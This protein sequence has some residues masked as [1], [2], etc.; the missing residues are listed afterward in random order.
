M[1]VVSEKPSRAGAALKSPPTKPHPLVSLVLLCRWEAPHIQKVMDS[2]LA[3]EDPEGGFEVIVADGMSDDG[4]REILA[5]V[6]ATDSRVRVIDNPGRIASAGLNAALRVARGQVIIRMD[7]HTHYAPDYVRQCVA[8]LERTGADNVGGPWVAQAKGYLGEAIAAAFQSPFAVGG[9]RGHLP[10][11]EGPVDTVYLGCWKREAFERFGGFDEALVRNQDDEHNLRILRGGGRIW[12]SPKIRSWYHSR[13]SLRGLFNQYLQYGYWKVQVIRKHGQPAS[14]RH[15]VPGACLLGVLLLVLTVLL[16]FSA[17]GLCA[18][19]STGGRLA[20]SLLGAALVALGSVVFSYL[21]AL[22]VAALHSA[23]RTKWKLLP[24]LP[25]VFCC[26]HFGY[27]C[28]FLRGLL[29]FVILHR[30]AAPSLSRL[31]RETGTRGK[32][33]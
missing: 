25:L 30:R 1:P 16:S 23:R 21:L 32:P 24:C 9:A 19:G 7:A 20:S 13:T 26:Y 33:G 10:H 14:L 18:P 4:T 29:E 6:A 28:G 15:L 8:V 22:L 3:Q 5:K 11:Y 2:I 27:G 31:T 17:R 12:Q